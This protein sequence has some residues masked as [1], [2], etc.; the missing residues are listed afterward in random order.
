MQHFAKTLICLLNHRKSEAYPLKDLPTINP[1]L[2]SRVEPFQPSPFAKIR[3]SIL[4]T[5]YSLFWSAASHYDSPPQ[6]DRLIHSML[7]IQKRCS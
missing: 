1:S 3:P 2:A 6:N 5:G 4:A 7:R